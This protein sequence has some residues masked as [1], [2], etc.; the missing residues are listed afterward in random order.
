MS[1]TASLLEAGCPHEK[2]TTQAESL[3]KLQVWFHALKATFAPAASQ[4]EYYGTIS[5]GTPPQVFTVV[6]DTGSS[7]LWV[8]SISCTSLAC[9]K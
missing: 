4:M 5:I 8:P 7:N 3:G 1:L 6:F 9:R 2:G